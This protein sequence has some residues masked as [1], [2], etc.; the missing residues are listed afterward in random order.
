MENI[1]L[2]KSKRNLLK[3]K[4]K[5]IITNNEM[6]LD[7]YSEENFISIIN[8]NRNYDKTIKYII[9]IISYYMKS[10]NNK[11][12]QKKCFKL[13]LLLIQNI[14]KEE[15]EKH[16]TSLLI[17][18]QEN[19]NDLPIEISFELILQNI[20]KFE[21]K[22]FEILNG[23]CIHNIKKN[24]I[25]AQKEALLCYEKLILNFENCNENKNVILKSFIDNIIFNLKIEFPMNIY[26]LMICLNRIVCIAKDNFN[27]YIQLTVYY[28]I[29]NLFMKDNDIKLITLEIINNII[30]F[31]QEKMEGFKNEI[32]YYFRKLLDDKSLEINIKRILL[33]ILKRLNININNDYINLNNKKE[34]KSKKIIQNNLEKKEEILIV[35]N[36]D[37]ELNI[38]NKDNNIKSKKLKN[39]K[40]KNKNDDTIYKKFIKIKPNKIHNKNVKIEIFVKNNS[41]N[42]IKNSNRKFTP[43]NTFK[44]KREEFIEHKNNKEKYHSTYINEEEYIN[45]IKMWF[46]LDKNSK[47]NI[48]NLKKS[49]I[50]DN[51][52][53][54]N[55]KLIIEKSINSQ[56][57]VN[58]D[59]K[60]DPKLDLIMNDILQISKMQTLLA[61]KIISLEKNTYDRISFFKSRIDE[62][63]RKVSPNCSELI[64]IY[65]NKLNKN[66]NNELISINNDNELNNSKNNNGLYSIDNNEIIK[67][68]NIYPSNV[69]NEKLILF[70][71]S[72]NNKSIYLLPIIKEEQ[73]IEIDNN[74]IED[75]INKLIDYLNQGIFI[76]ECINFIK[77]VFIKHKMKFQLNT[78]KRLLSSLDKLLMNKNILSNED[79]LNIS[80]IISTINIDKI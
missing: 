4:I 25:H 20:G 16:L 19:I 34:I 40:I 52:N 45:P 44:R 42:V 10:S 77:K 38:R 79:S 9:K 58:K 36:K 31:N 12:L 50:K 47:N 76:H 21:L 46:N 32:Y 14:S 60:E 64:S 37:Y 35:K 71:N 3:D 18:L 51:S 29:N 6:H 41:T 59:S 74:L 57:N 61:D 15:I 69:L 22:I 73:V 63:E 62:L 53:D 24:E 67:Y 17:V 56:I 27:N 72:N 8:T 26:Q 65:N 1:D 11:N 55:N 43:L 66:N 33:N 70:L 68:K 5:D 7:N 75:V 23:F 39:M 80:L 78:I 54:K 49:K 13:F 2:P 48:K 30:K 28:I